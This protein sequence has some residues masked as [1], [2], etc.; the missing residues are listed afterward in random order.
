[1]RP[2]AKGKRVAKTSRNGPEAALAA[3]LAPERRALRRAAGLSAVAAAVWPVQAGLVAY[4][5]AGLLDGPKAAPWVLALG[6]FALAVLRAG[7][8]AWG[9]ALGFAAGQRILQ[10]LRAEL[11]A[12]EAGAL[13]GM[14]A[15]A[16]A[17][18]AGEKLELLLPYV[19]RYGPAM[20]RASFAPLLILALALWHSWAVAAVLLMTGP[21]IF[22]FMALIGMTAQETSARQLGEMASVNDLLVERLSTLVDIRLL[23]AGERVVAGFAARAEGLR[24]RTMAVLRVAFLSSTV[25]ELFAAIGVAMV[26]V[27]VGF[28]LL[29]VIGFGTWGAV[30]TPFAGIW[31]LL[32]VPEFF[33][34]LRDLAS[35]W[36][37]RAA[38]LALAAEWADWQALA[39]A[40]ILGGTA[41]VVGPARIEV[42][43]LALPQRGLIWPDFAVAPGEA[44]AI[45]GPSG[46]GKTTLLQ[47]LAGLQAV[48]GVV[49]VAGVPLDAGNAA[50]WRARLGWM[51]Q[52]PHFLAASVQ[53]NIRLGRAGDLQTALQ[54]A[55][56]AEVVARAGGLTARLGET[57]G[58]LSGGEAR[59]LTLA[60][61]IYGAP[62]VILAD[63]PTADLDAETAEAVTRGLLAQAARGATLIV[64][65]HDERLAARLGRVIR[66]GGC[67]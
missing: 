8:A 51:P 3:L 48:E 38:A 17:A 33:Q 10:R 31:L 4:G 50:G 13:E 61:A 7:L 26:A 66:L 23:G 46:V 60:R 59:R 47:V 54:G 16:V 14:G 18:L 37:D 12:R 67:T 19:T 40:R 65:T 55:A 22:V 11:V 42:R 45:M 39:P 30:L 24:A 32:L 21:I 20:A 15:G 43:G 44:L 25:L 27:Y 53:E 56:V 5:I 36:H 29:G 49:L 64:A 52:A 6:F 41:A 28:S 62:D 1:L 34:P 35:G 2:K 58:G 9:E 57:G 63:E